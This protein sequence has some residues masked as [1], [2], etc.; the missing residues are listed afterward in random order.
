MMNAEL[1]NYQLST[2]PLTFSPLQSRADAETCAR[3]MAESEPWLTLGRKYEGLLKAVLNPAREIYLAKS[4]DEMSGFVMI[5]MQ[6][7]FTG[8]IQTLFVA[9]S[10]RSRGTGAELM[11]YAEARIFQQTPNVFLCVSS[12][13]TGA[14]KFYK[15]I[16]YTVI[17]ELK[18]Y[19][20]SGYD[21][22]LMRKTIA[23]LVDYDPQVFLNKEQAA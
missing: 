19:L 1:S 21:E 13:N 11:A 4:G 8:Y 5:N 15:R 17:G 10:W 20:V 9:P 2:T 18:D 22:I 3:M 7:A 14:Q 16:G 12:F 6:G 23:P